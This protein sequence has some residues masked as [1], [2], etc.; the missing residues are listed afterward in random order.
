MMS[1]SH[2]TLSQTTN[3]KLFQTERVKDNNFEFDE[4][5][6][7][8]AKRVENTVGK[9]EIAHYKKF[10]LFHRECFQKTRCSHISRWLSKSA[11]LHSLEYSYDLG[12][13]SSNHSQVRSLSLSQRF[14]YS[15][16]T[17]LLIG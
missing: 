17:Q 6:G 12:M 5:G 16:V 11:P 15:N 10:P 8:F 1:H 9:G 14:V 4:T 3:F 7:K 2:L 13:Y